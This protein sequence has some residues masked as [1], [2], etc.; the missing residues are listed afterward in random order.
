MIDTFF[1]CDC[2]G[3][4]GTKSFENLYRHEEQTECPDDNAISRKF[5]KTKGT[6][7]GFGLKSVF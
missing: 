1:A 7:R 6:V 2:G 5:E 3:G 4:N